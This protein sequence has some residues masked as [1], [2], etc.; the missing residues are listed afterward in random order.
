MKIVFSRS[1]Q[2]S[3]DDPGGENM[4]NP[5]TMKRRR[6]KS[7]FFFQAP[8]FPPIPS[9]VKVDEESDL[10]ENFSGF[11]SSMNEL[12]AYCLSCLE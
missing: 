1:G 6:S 10:S 11:V 4:R 9:G 7:C 5:T 12:R 2:A 3:L 8:D